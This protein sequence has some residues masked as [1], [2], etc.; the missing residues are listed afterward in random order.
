MLDALN[1]PS[2]ALM[3]TGGPRAIPQQLMRGTLTPQMHIYIPGAMSVSCKHALVHGLLLI[4]MPPQNSQHK[5]SATY[6]TSAPTEQQA[7]IHLPLFCLTSCR[8]PGW[9]QHESTMR[10]VLRPNTTKNTQQ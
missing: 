7:F 1:I 6:N 5:H 3:H 2:T 4:P 9:V 8:L 10:D